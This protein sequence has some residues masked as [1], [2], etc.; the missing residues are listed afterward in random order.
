[1]LLKSVSAR[2]SPAEEISQSIQIASQDVLFPWVSAAA[3]HPRNRHRAIA[4][5]LED[6][7]RFLTVA[8]YRGL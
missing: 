7:E 6:P 3:T 4:V 2:F 8:H 1:V 5:A